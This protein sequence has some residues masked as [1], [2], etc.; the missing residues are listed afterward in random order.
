MNKEQKSEEGKMSKEQQSELVHIAK[1]V[2]RILGIPLVLFAIVN[3]FLE[4]PLTS[5]IVSLICA[6]LLSIWS[7]CFKRSSFTPLIIAWLSLAVVV[8]MGIIIWPKTMTING[9]V[10]DVNG[11]P[12]CNETVKLI[13]ASG[14]TY[15]IDTNL[16]GFYQFS[17]V[18]LGRYTIRV[19]GSE[20]EGKS[21]GIFIQE[22]LQNITLPTI[23]VQ[24]ETPT[25]IPNTSTATNEPDTPTPN[26]PTLTHT[27]QPTDTIQPTETKQPTSTE[28]IASSLNVS[29]LEDFEQEPP[30]LVLWDMG[31][32]VYTWRRTTEMPYEG[33]YSLR[34]DYSKSDTYQF[35]G[36]EIPEGTYHRNFA[37]FNAVVIWAY[38]NGDIL[39]KLEDSSGVGKDV[40][41]QKSVDGE[42]TQLVF[43]YS[44]LRTQL[45][46]NDIKN[47]LFF[48]A[49]GDPN[50]TGTIYIDNIGLAYIN[51]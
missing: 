24:V 39:L 7:V 10:T 50:A 30:F 29:L 33:N 51:N 11:Q 25:P 1:V 14:K 26:P 6:I 8:L 13:D 18:P 27:V 21:T 4:Q 48:I 32:G 49:P 5:L 31:E 3:S 41:T 45:N 16:E 46:L 22:I 28:I 19:L 44:L 17:D 12:V 37:Q 47:L 36:M 40:Q 9:F 15:E 34:V 20:I 43:N 38:G 23:V 35:I 2:G 42:W